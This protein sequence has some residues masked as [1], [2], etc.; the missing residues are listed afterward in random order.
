MKAPPPRK[1]RTLAVTRGTGFVGDHFLRMAVA[2]GHE[3]RALTRKWRPP[4]EGI[5][6]IEGALDRPETLARLCEG[7]EAVV[8]IAVRSTPPTG[9]ASKR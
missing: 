4:E 8:H 2:A 7:A 3:V 1:V 6:W 9:P 5:D